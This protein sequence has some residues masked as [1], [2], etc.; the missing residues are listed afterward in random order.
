MIQFH[1]YNIRDDCTTLSTGLVFFSR[2][3]D[4]GSEVPYAMG[5]LWAG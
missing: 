4:S 3:L 2:L 5:I 1:P